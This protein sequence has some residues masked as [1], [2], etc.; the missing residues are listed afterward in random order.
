MF[1]A[2]DTVGK[3]LGAINATNLR[4]VLLDSTALMAVIAMYFQYGAT[5]CSFVT[6]LA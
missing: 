4:A 6:A 3:D 2:A 5:R 1:E